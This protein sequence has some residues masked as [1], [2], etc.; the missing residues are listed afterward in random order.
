MPY[1]VEIP[2]SVG[3]LFDKIT[4][5]E[6]KKKNIRCTRRRAMVSD[7]L[8]LLFN[9][10]VALNPTGDLELLIEKLR[11]INETLWGAENLIRRFERDLRFDNSYVEVPRNI[12]NLN[13]QRAETKRQISLMMNSTIVEVKEHI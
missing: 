3:E 4:I 7:E 8:K 11:V 12:R 10:S 5:L 13:D 1:T 9:R 2:V 6:I